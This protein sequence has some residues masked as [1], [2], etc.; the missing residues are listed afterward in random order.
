MYKEKSILAIIPARGGSKGISKK[1]IRDMAGKPLMAWSIEAGRRSKYIDRIIVSTEDTEIRDI[2]LK[3]GA[4][5][6]FLRPNELAQDNTPGVD[7]VLYTIKKL[8]NEEKNKYDYTILLQP[9]SPLRNEKHI[10]EAI[11]ILLS[12]NINR[13][14]SLISVTELEHPVYW[15]RLIGVNDEL[16]DYLKYDKSKNF[17]RQHFNKVYRLNGA[18]YLIETN[19]LLKYKNFETDNTMAY[20]MDKKT[21][22]D[23]D[24]IDDFELAEYYIN[25]GLR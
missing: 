21:T 25:K 23:I 1:N 16:K 11:E 15:N 3:S 10:D 19:A 18:I 8:I 9:T 17:R 24:C 2:A 12:N 13:F 5:V 22:I 20:I 7:P 4:E 6:P 14:N